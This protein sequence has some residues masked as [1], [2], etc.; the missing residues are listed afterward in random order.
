MANIKISQLNEL[1]V[2]TEDDFIPVVDSGSLTTYHVTIDTV[3]DYLSASGSVPSSSWAS[4]SLTTISASW[5]SHSFS[6]E[7]ASWASSS[8]SSSWPPAL[9]TASLYDITSSWTQNSLMS[10]SASYAEI[11]DT[12]SISLSSS[13]SDSSS[14]ADNSVSSSYSTQ[15]YYS[16]ISDSS[17]V[18]VSSS[19]ALTASYLR[20]TQSSAS[21]ITKF[22]NNVG[23]SYL[24]PNCG[25]VFCAGGNELYVYNLQKSTG[26]RNFVAI[27]MKTNEATY[28]LQWPQNAWRLYG[29]AFKSTNDNSRRLII[30]SDTYMYEYNLDTDSLTSHTGGASGHYFDLPVYVNWTDAS[31][32]D[33][34]SLYGSYYAASGGDYPNVRLKRTYWNG[35]SWVHNGNVAGDLNL[36]YILNNTEFRKFFNNSTAVSNLLLWDYNPIKNRYYFMDD[37][38]GYLHILSQTTGNIIT[39]WNA[40]YITYEK[41]LAIPIPSLAQWTDAYVEKIT[42]DYDLDTG[43]E[44]GILMVRRGNQSLTEGTATYINWPEYGNW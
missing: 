6:A 13:Y 43:D 41:T 38:G 11:S 7:S 37:T 10:I 12:S 15:S 18:S 34:Y 5:S 26:Y 28:K 33:V 29:K 3:G 20:G 22:F 16:Q 21:L 23:I 27:N 42:I 9:F 4:S 24:V 8:I 44:L 40:S 1:T 17:S 32:P 36:Y 25:G 14:W 19:Y 39:H 2:I 30:H 35:A 31:H